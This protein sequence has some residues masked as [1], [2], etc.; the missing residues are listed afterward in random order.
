MN[1]RLCLQRLDTHMTQSDD[2]AE[3]VDIRK[4]AVI[5]STCNLSVK[6]CVCVRPSVWGRM[7][8]RVMRVNSL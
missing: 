3:K 4:S 6:K 8:D 1:L 7:C 2:F 5:H